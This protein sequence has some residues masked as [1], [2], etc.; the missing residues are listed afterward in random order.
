[1]KER[2]SVR[3]GLSKDNIEQLNTINEICEDYRE[4]GYRLTLRQLYYQL[5]SKDI[6]PNNQKEY[7]KISHILKQGRMG[8][9]VDWD[10]IEDRLRIP[11][12]PYWC[13][14][15]E[16]AIEDTISQYRVDRMSNQEFYI[17]LWVEKDA[18]SGVL[19]PITQHYHIN[20]MINRGYSSCSA[21]YDAANRIKQANNGGK[22]CIILYLGDHDPSGLD[23]VRDI[24][25]RLKDFEAIVEVEHIG[26]TSAQVKKYNPPPNPVKFTDSRADAYIEKF[27]RSSWEVDALNPKTLNSLIRGR[28]EKLIDL[29]LFQEMLDQEKSDK[30][31]LR[32]YLE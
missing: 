15:V 6:I 20:L 21:M 7:T 17:E 19:K 9:I 5:V 1:M 12:L 32:G 10:I 25:S 31:K 16:G 14:G 30:E 3:L 22:A 27:G 2:F 24:S 4:Q 23:M 18:L 26:L 11:F 28:I 29:E 8:G 13:N